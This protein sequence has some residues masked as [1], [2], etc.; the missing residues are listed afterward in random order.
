MEC[1]N[2]VTDR[3]ILS[4][5]SLGVASIHRGSDLKQ[6]PHAG[7]LGS[8]RVAD[9]TGTEADAEQAHHGFQ[10]CNIGPDV[11]ANPLEQ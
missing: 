3:P 7:G 9:A 4:E 2:V 1:A 6:F 11:E 5:T 8:V 10:E